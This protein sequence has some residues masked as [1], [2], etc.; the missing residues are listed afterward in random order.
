[1]RAAISTVILAIALAA[2]APHCFHY[3]HHTKATLDKW[4]D[5]RTHHPNWKPSITAEEIC[6]IPLIPDEPL[7]LI[8]DAPEM[9]LV[10]EPLN[11]LLKPE[12]PP[13]Y[14]L[15][16]WVR[17]EDVQDGW[18]ME[19]TPI[20]A[21]LLPLAPT[22]EPSTLILFGSGLVGLVVLWGKS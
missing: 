2:E 19:P 11:A 20:R 15:D 7:Q 9:G 6:T 12:E 1:M 5:W 22:P 4:A 14:D 17:D 16:R 10:G 18:D 13:I 3:H 8:P 21:P